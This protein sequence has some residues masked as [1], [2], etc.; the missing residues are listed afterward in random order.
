MNQTDVSDTND[1]YIQ[2]NLW[3]LCRVQEP[4]MRYKAA[5][6]LRCYI[7][8]ELKKA[9]LNLVRKY[10]SQRHLTWKLTCEELFQCV[11]DDEGKLLRFILNNENGLLQFE[12]DK[13]QRLLVLDNHGKLQPEYQPFT[14]RVL[15]TFDPNRNPRKSLANWVYLLV[16]QDKEIK[17][18]FREHGIHRINPWVLLSKTKPEQLQ[19]I[20]ELYKFP[21]NQIKQDV[22]VL[23][24]LRQVHQQEQFQRRSNGVGERGELK[25]TNSLIKKM[26]PLLQEQ[27]SP[28]ASLESLVSK[29]ES[30][31]K[32]LAQYKNQSSSSVSLDAPIS[33]TEGSLHEVLPCYTFTNDLEQLERLEIEKFYCQIQQSFQ[34][35]YHRQRIELLNHALKETI[36]NRLAYLKNSHRM[37]CKSLKYVPALRHFYRDGLTQMEIVSLVKLRDQNDLSRLLDLKNLITDSMQRML[38]LLSDIFLDWVRNSPELELAQK[39][40]EEPDI[41]SNLLQEETRDIESLFKQAVAEIHNSKN[42][43]R[44]S[45]VARQICYLLEQFI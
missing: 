9:C 13:E 32:F 29:L 28:I 40:K 45:L 36:L 7:S 11:L 16:G 42:R 43:S 17:R 38:V 37:S 3:R 10:G 14:F 33:G 6:N 34:P 19:R 35:L 23:K 21:S 44:N 2:T 30:I 15:Q 24:I 8:H 27:Q 12:R 5:L 25:I 1:E 20:E 31:F 22:L 39:L 26:L 4:E 18:I 41:G